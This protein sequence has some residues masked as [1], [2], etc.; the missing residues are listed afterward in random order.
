MNIDGE[1]HY[2]D[3]LNTQEVYSR[4]ITGIISKETARYML[5]LIFLTFSAHHALLLRTDCSTNDI[6][7]YVNGT[8]SQI[9]IRQ[10]LCTEMKKKKGLAYSLFCAFVPS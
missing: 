6:S 5:H 9:S 10:R 7:V 2:S 3:T 1:Y 4:H 8:C